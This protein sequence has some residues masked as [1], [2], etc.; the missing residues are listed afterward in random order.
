MKGVLTVTHNSIIPRNAQFLQVAYD[1]ITR[2][3]NVNGWYEFRL[4]GPDKPHILWWNGDNTQLQRILAECER[5]NERGYNVYCTLNPCTE[6]PEGSTRD[7]NISRRQL[8][9]VDVDPARPKLEV[10]GKLTDHIPST[11]DEQKAAVRVIYAVRD[12]LQAQGVNPLVL[13]D[14][15]NGA[16][17]Y[18]QCDLPNDAQTTS[19]VHTLLQ[20]LDKRFSTDAAHIDTSVANA[21]RIAR[22]PGYVNY[23]GTELPER[24]YRR[25]RVVKWYDAPTVM[26]MPTL[27][28]L[29]NDLRQKLGILQEKPADP[30]RN[31]KHAGNGGNDETT[32]AEWF[33]RHI[34][35]DA[36]VALAQQHGYQPV[37]QRGEY[38]EMTRPGKDTGISGGFTDLPG[39]L[40]YHNFSTNDPYL[41]ENETVSAFEFYARLEHAGDMSSAARAVMEG[42][43]ELGI[44]PMPSAS[45]TTNDRQMG[46]LLHYKYAA[47]FLQQ[48]FRR[49]AGSNHWLRWTG[50][51]WQEVD[52]DTVVSALMGHLACVYAEQYTRAAKRYA[53]SQSEADAERMKYWASLQ[54]E[55]S[56][57][58]RMS[59]VVKYAGGL[60][61]LQVTRSQ[62]DADPWL[63]NLENG[64][65]DLRTRQLLPHTREHYITKMAHVEYDP[66]ATS[67]A[68]EAHLQLCIPNENIRRHLQRSLGRAVVG[69]VLDETL[70]IWYGKDGANGKSTTARVIM[71][72]LGDYAQKAAP[73]LLVRSKHDR[74]PT[75]IA[76]LAGSR[77][78]FSVEIDEGDQLNVALVKD[79]TGGDTLKARFLYENFFEFQRTF[80]LFLAVNHLPDVSAS[81]GGTWRRLRVVPWTVTIP[82]HMRRPQ[83]DVVRELTTGTNG[84]AILNWLLDGLQDFL[85]DRGWTPVE[86]LG[87]TEQY[88]AEQDPVTLFVRERCDLGG[89]YAVEFHK[90]YDAYTSWCYEQGVKVVD[91]TQFTRSL[92]ELGVEKRRHNNNLFQCHGIRLKPIQ[93]GPQGGGGT[94]DD[95][96]VSNATSCNVMYTNS[97]KYSNSTLYKDFTETHYMT[98]HANVSET[99]TPSQQSV[100][101][102]QD[103]NVEVGVDGDDI[104]KPI[105]PPEPFL[106]SRRRGSWESCTFG[107]IYA[108]YAQWCRG[109]GGQPV[110]PDEFLRAL[111]RVAEVKRVQNLPVKYA[112][113]RGIS[114]ESSE[115]V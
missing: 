50:K 41:Q 90:L 81:D 20:L 32:P 114:V 15:G 61:E 31:G 89:L 113:V 26:N 75:E 84:S 74:H 112:Q 97:V 86:V 46:D 64:T 35:M 105:I 102:C 111:R 18:L 34:A 52:A 5:Y 4:L 96:S 28:K 16:Q 110:R 58:S 14:S 107:A 69:A 108:A 60:P 87:A 44:P 67:P 38:Y 79:L 88:R 101:T 73:K 39:V 17:L 12:Y 66:N 47:E 63:L 85:N 82:E 30:K 2:T 77:V 24:P 49:I 109:R 62:L 29:V 99:T 36:M 25:S 93:P 43:P 48:N 8:I 22:V 92:K 59:S 7:E 104:G 23:K 80:S 106:L 9:L 100:A 71:T 98:L 83:D 70:D 94:N 115:E 65:L 37:G 95:E 72:L 27:E 10:N 56:K 45:T 103:A 33:N 42:I 55:A 6:K 13:V 57:F 53:S 68:W 76:A 91:K 1:F 21:A 54:L 19:L 51:R 3:R 40:C 11:L 78:V